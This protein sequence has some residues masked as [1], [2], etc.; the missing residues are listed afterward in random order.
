MMHPNPFM[1][2]AMADLKEL[3]L[4]NPFTTVA[5]VAIV[6]AALAT[7]IIRSE[8]ADEARRQRERANASDPLTPAS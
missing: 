6:I 3:A 8:R 2:E 1:L 7:L 5:I 4:A